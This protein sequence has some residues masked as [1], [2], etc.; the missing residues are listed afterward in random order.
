M[1]CGLYSGNWFELGSSDNL[2]FISLI[3][4]VKTTPSLTTSNSGFSN[5]ETPSNWTLKSSSVNPSKQF[6]IFSS[7]TVSCMPYNNVTSLFGH[8]D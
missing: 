1:I 7:L 6:N 4:G 5:I 2:L 8:Q 3:L